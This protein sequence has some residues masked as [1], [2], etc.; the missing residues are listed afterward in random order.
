MIQKAVLDEEF[1]EDELPVRTEIGT[2]LVSDSLVA[3]KHVESQ[4]IKALS[5]AERDLL[6]L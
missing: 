3:R 2:A 5:K 1:S 4:R 6:I